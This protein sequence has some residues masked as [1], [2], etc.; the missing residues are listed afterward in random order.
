LKRREVAVRFLILEICFAAPMTS[1][2]PI[3]EYL[4][5]RSKFSVTMMHPEGMKVG[6]WNNIDGGR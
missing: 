3:F 4:L 5:K 1:L 6:I 2:Y